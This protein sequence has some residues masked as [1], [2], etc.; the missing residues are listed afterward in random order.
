MSQHY[1]VDVSADPVEVP[2]RVAMVPQR[3]PVRFEEDQPVENLVMSFPN[4]VIRSVICF[5]LV[6]IAL[7]LL[8]LF[9][10]APLEELANPQHTPNPAKAPWYF[11][12]LQELLHFFPPVVAGVVL[13]TLV[14][15]ALIVIPY[16]EINI[17]R[18]GLW[19]EDRQRTVV[20][21]TTIIVLFCVIT[22]MF[23]A[24]DIVI[25]TLILYSV[26]LIPYFKPTTEGWIGWLGRRSL[27]EWIMTWFAI[28]ATVLT[29]VGTFFR[30]PGWS[31]VW[32]W[33]SGIY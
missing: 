16:F 19:V 21:L 2:K 31:W 32:P 12:G 13:P 3:V 23:S 22:G 11:L 20:L 18:E 33:K 15:V 1:E 7:A 29:L 28:V 24:F 9:V 6:V 26:A 4:L 10:N 5:Q 8:A 14:V 30:G 17:K 25:P 27:A